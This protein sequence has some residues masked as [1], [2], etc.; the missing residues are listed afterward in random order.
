MGRPLCLVELCAATAASTQRRTVSWDDAQRQLSE[1]TLRDR[2][3][4]PP[5]CHGGASPALPV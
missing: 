2:I 4:I 5:S 3:Y 1:P